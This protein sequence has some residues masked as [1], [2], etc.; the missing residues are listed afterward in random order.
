MS[1][2]KQIMLAIL[3]TIKETGDAGTPLGP[4]YAALMTT[5]MDLD[6]FN[7]FISGMTDAGFIRV[8]NHVAYFI[9]QESK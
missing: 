7:G 5:G 9:N 6:Q 1:I 3:D 8:S 2:V 4:L